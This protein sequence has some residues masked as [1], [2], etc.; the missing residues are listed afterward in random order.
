MLPYDSRD[1]NKYSSLHY[2]DSSSNNNSNTNMLMEGKFPD[3]VR[4]LLDFKQMDFEA[5]FD[6]LLLLVS[7][8]PQQ[9]SVKTCIVLIVTIFLFL[10]LKLI[11]F[12]RYTSFYYRK[13]KT[14]SIKFNAMTLILW[15]AV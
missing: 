2:N 13:R 1:M 3:Y 7:S 14:I 12:D 8:N 11:I 6:S 4:R 15:Y 10:I 9:M 5:A